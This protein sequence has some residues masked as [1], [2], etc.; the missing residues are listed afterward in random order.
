MQGTKSMPIVDIDRMFRR[1]R[2][3][4]RSHR[5]RQ[6]E[7][8]DRLRAQPADRAAGSSADDV[9]GLGS[10]RPRGTVIRVRQPRCTPRPAD[11]SDTGSTTYSTA[12][13][14]DMVVGASARVAARAAPKDDGQMGAAET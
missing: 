4:P 13:E 2:R 6:Y 14:R 1:H 7:A 10:R 11:A 12:V 8:I 3:P 5:R 9:A